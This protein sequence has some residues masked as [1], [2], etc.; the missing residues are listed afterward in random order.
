MSTQPN[1][2]V[3]VNLAAAGGAVGPAGAGALVGAAGAGAGAGEH[4]VAISA[5]AAITTTTIII[6]DLI[7]LLLLGIWPVSKA[8]M[9]L[10][11]RRCRHHNEMHARE[12]QK[13]YAVL[14]TSFVK[15]NTKRQTEGASSAFEKIF[16]RNT[17]FST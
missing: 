5:R 16:N 13:I 11:N 9:H 12:L 1:L 7:V 10:L 6:F 17:R 2:S 4:A 8:L 14:I 15:G 3:Q